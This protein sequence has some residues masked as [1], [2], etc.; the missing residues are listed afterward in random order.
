MQNVARVAVLA[1]FNDLNVYSFSNRSDS[2][3][4]RNTITPVDL[5]FGPCRLSS[6]LVRSTLEFIQRASTMLKSANDSGSN[7]L[8]RTNRLVHRRMADGGAWALLN[9]RRNAS[10]LE[11]VT[12]SE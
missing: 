1:C 3:Q 10:A 9:R 7:T 8:C 11:G 12:A 4:A 6:R 5:S 2:S